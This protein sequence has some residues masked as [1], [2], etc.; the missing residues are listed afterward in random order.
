M[1]HEI[2]LSLSGLDSPIWSQARGGR[3]SA[4]DS[5]DSFNQYVSPPERA[6]LDTLARL[7]ELHVKIR[8]ATT[9]LSKS[10]ESLVCRAVSSSIKEV[11]LVQFLSKVMEVEAAVLKKDA[12]FV[13]AYEIVPLSSVVAE[14]APWT[15]RLEWLWSL[16]QDLDP[17]SMP[18]KREICPCA[19][20]MLDLL[21]KETHTGYSEI[22][23]MA[24][25]LLTVAQRTWMR[26]TSLWILYGRLPTTGGEDFCIKSNPNPGSVMDAFVLVPGLSPALLT[27]SACHALLSAGSALSQLRTQAAPGAT[28]TQS[29]NNSSLSL[30]QDHLTVL[31]A[32]KYP[33]NPALLENAL[34]IINNSI[35]ENALSH[36][37]PRSQVLQLLRLI[38]R[39]MLLGQGE[40]AVSLI[41]HADGRVQVRRHDQRANRP[42]RKIGKLDDLSV[43]Q[44]E[45]SGI[46]SKTLAELAAL[47][48]DDFEDDTFNLARKLLALRAATDESDSR[49]IA[50]LLPIRTFLQLILPAHSPLHIFLSAED[51]KTYATIN[52][53]LLSIHR[54]ELH[55]S[56]LWKLSSQRRCHP[57]PVGPPSSASQSGR[58]SLKA[59]RARDA[60][61]NA[62][63]RGHWTC[64]S[65]LLFLLN[66]LE[67]YLQG[68]VVHN[69]SS[70]F[71]EWLEGKDR[72]SRSSRPGTASSAGQFGLSQNSNTA[73]QED[74]DGP[75]GN[76]RSASEVSLCNE[77][78]A[79]PEERRLHYN[80][81]RSAQADRSSRSPLPPPSNSLAR[82]RSPGRGRG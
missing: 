26:A 30:L 55:L 36:I 76:G 52:A 29:F 2:L 44:A 49:Q 15:R 58:A 60:R 7:H 17:D 6:M 35:S 25:A 28:A 74:P 79:L 45:L 41:S 80:A 24:V 9:R 38:W 3:P 14:F 64:A 42:V 53:Y 11:H 51:T 78:R 81:R 4:G 39:Y 31:G 5:G 22:E 69:C 32:L 8:G 34:S 65:K 27:P 82:T 18:G 40:F 59:S 1:L 68:E 56:A 77:C 67:V 47:H 62:R 16:V 46:L 73:D 63:T 23:D 12:A 21:E 19:A 20:S 50:T 70:H 71:R 43:N 37:L 57:S 61:R 13:G 48:G 72:G 66:E 10:H 54:G 75:S 33:L